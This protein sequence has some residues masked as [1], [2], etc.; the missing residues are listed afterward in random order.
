MSMIDAQSAEI[1]KKKRA[2]MV[3]AI[4]KKLEE[5]AARPILSWRIDYFAHRPHVKGLIPQNSVYNYG[6]MQDVWSDK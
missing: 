2:A 1:D 5:D 4:Q 6:R 3:D